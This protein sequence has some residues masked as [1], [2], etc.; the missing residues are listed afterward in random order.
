MNNQY[1]AEQIRQRRRRQTEIPRQ[2]LLAPKGGPL[3]GDLV[4]AGW[5]HDERDMVEDYLRRGFVVRACMGY[6]P[7]RICGRANGSLELSDGTYVW[8]EGLAHY[9]SDHAVR[10]P[11]PF[12]SHVQAMIE[13]LEAS[14]RDESWWRGQT[15]QRSEG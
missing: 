10:L 2:E 6:S 1:A 15:L 8:P 13:T 11:E 4:D 14:G 3:A 12:V 7:C 5:D 9:V